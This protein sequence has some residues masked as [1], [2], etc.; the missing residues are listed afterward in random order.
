MSRAAAVTS[1][2]LRLLPE[3][4]PGKTR[5]VNL[6]ARPFRTLSSP[7]IADKFGNRLTVPSL[8]EPI[9]LALFGS[10]VYEAETLAAIMRYLPQDGVFLDVG[11]NIGALAL[12]VASLRPRARIVAVEADPRI[13][14]ILRKNAADNA[15]RNVTV[16]ECV[17]GAETAAVSF[18]RAPADHFGMGSV[19]PQFTQ[20]GEELPQRPLDAVLDETGVDSVDVVK[21][22]IE[23]AEVGALR[24]LA[25]RL[26]GTRPPV[27]IFEFADWA[28]TRIAGQRAGDAQRF[29]QSLG[30]RLFA[31]SDGGTPAAITEP[32]MIG[33]AMLLAT[34]DRP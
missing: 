6:A 9:A 25:R 14:A 23:G 8:L 10:G 21:L 22:D 12:P 18:Y 2:L 17:A 27:V 31:M 16:V 26:S 1:G 11:A 13:A 24:G 3:R 15:R 20:A 30:Y 29:L 28:E 4:M 33:A 34:K 19:G 32:L 7:Q 5:L